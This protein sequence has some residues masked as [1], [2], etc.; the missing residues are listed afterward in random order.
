MNGPKIAFIS[1][2]SVCSVVLFLHGVV[3]G[4]SCENIIKVLLF[5]YPLVMVLIDC[6]LNNY[7]YLM[8]K[9]IK[10]SE[11]R[12]RELRWRLTVQA[13]PFFI[14]TTLYVFLNLYS[15]LSPRV[16]FCFL[17]TCGFIV[18][19]TM[20]ALFD[21]LN[22]TFFIPEVTLFGATLSVSSPWTNVGLLLGYW[23]VYSALVYDDM[24]YIYAGWYDFMKYVEAHKKEKE[25]IGKGDGGG[26]LGKATGKIGSVFGKVLGKMK[27]TKS[28]TDK[29]A[30]NS[31]QDTQAEP[32][33]KDATNSL[34]DT[35]AEP[36][37]EH[38]TISE[39]KASEDTSAQ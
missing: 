6:K 21:V 23:T 3:S 29:D 9:D 28:T 24:Y 20:V 31:L 18:G 35:Q 1:I 17:L 7:F 2:I 10:E 38:A 13:I 37:E 26:M 30:T 39:S 15:K 32:T 11:L 33:D 4:I 14:F 22:W 5:V 8:S 34:Q 19:H 25:Y 36:T 16:T 27:K 12:R